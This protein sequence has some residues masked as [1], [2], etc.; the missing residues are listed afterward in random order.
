MKEEMQLVDTSQLS[1]EFVK[2][3]TDIGYFK[4]CAV[5]A[6]QN[7]EDYP[8]KKRRFLGDFM[9]PNKKVRITN[10]GYKEPEFAVVVPLEA[11]QKCPYYS[12]RYSEYKILELAK[13]ILNYSETL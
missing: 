5:W 9:T 4:Y 8:E 12:H 10:T 13:E 7:E 11:I 1:E 2:N 3:M 6:N